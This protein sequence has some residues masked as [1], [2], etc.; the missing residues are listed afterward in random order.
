MLVVDSILIE[1]VVEGGLE[2]DV[3]SEV[4]RPGRG[5]EELCL[6]RD[7]VIVIEFLGGSLI[8]LAD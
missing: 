7:G 6:I 4:A 5:D 1:P 3:I 2:V 8:V